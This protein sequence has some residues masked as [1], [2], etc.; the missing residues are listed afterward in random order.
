[1]RGTGLLLG[2]K[3]KSDSRAFVNYLREHGLLTV[4]AGDNVF[5]VLPPLVIEDAHISE[6]IEKLS[7]AARA[8]EVP[9]AA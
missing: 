7:A 1:V 8:Y 4:A 5:R 3:M 9:Q 6:F 2:V